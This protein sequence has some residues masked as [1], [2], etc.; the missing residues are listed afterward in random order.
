MNH[1]F[2]WMVQY[3]HKIIDLYFKTFLSITYSFP[4]LFQQVLWW[5]HA[6]GI[7]TSINLI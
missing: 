4:L 5:V 3:I 6:Q 2:P 7:N 1:R